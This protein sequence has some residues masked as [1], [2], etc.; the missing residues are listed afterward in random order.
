MSKEDLEETAYR[1]I[2]QMILKH[3]YRPGEFLL[4]TELAE[5][6]KLSRTPVRQ[7]LQRLTAEGFL[8]KKR[9]KGCF[10]PLPS[11]G[12]AEQ[13]FFAREVI[14]S[15]TAAASAL[16]ATDSDVK[17]L[18]SLLEKEEKIMSSNNKAGYS[19]INEKFHIGIA[20]G[21]GNDYLKRYCTHIF[22]RANCY[23]FFFDSFYSRPDTVSPPTRLLTPAQ[24]KRILDAIAKHEPEEA[25]SA[26]REH[27]RCQYE[28]MLKPWSY[29]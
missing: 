8:D 15:Q 21:S 10:I 4:E 17:L 7:A 19:L 3:R 2:I 26:M 11:P 29:K 22:W 1:M 13:V 28:V 12:D 9:K 27:I 6:L 20:S 23:L 5:K 18:R 16:N 14:E 24:H 25:A